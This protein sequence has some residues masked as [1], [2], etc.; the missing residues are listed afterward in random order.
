MCIRD[1][2]CVLCRT[3]S[4]ECSPGSAESHQRCNKPHKEKWAD[5]DRQILIIFKITDWNWIKL[6]R[7]N[8]N[9]FSILG[10]WVL[11]NVKV[12]AQNLTVLWPHFEKNVLKDKDI[13]RQRKS[14]HM[15]WT[16]FHYFVN[17]PSLEWWHQVSIIGHIYNLKRVKT[18]K[19]ATNQWPD[20]MTANHHGKQ[21]EVKSPC[22][23]QP[24]ISKTY[25]LSNA[26]LSPELFEQLMQ[27]KQEN[28]AN[29]EATCRHFF[30]A[31]LLGCCTRRPPPSTPNHVR[32]MH[33]VCIG[34][35]L[36][37]S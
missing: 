2:H 6:S 9:M 22:L 8:C 17:L 12:F 5:T 23:W 37:V 36:Q 20:T 34:I 1:R 30:T 28:E 27:L 24:W 35:G 18:W 25:L 10:I 29:S 3:A 16:Q 32:R 31:C 26:M 21:M 14:N 4:P 13:I 11:N 15:I 19:V 7:N 33:M